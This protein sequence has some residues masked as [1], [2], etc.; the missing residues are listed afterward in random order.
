MILVSDL[1]DTLVYSTNLNNDAY[2]FALE[3]FGY[4]RVDDTARI[5][6][7]C[8]D[9][10]P[11]QILK[12][13]VEEKQQYF[14]LNWMKYRLILNNPLLK[15]LKRNGKQNCIL[16]TKANKERANA[17]IDAFALNKI[18]K[19]IIFDDKTNFKKSI[20]RIKV[21]TDENKIIFYENEESSFQN[22]KPI[23]IIDTTKT[24][25]FDVKGYLVRI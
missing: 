10:V 11:R 9:N 6:R 15:I 23:R 3:K 8:L 7:E 13:I 5:T 14:S 22:Y 20:K 19:D 16:W 24:D 17:I 21:L 1:D 25:I 2:N 18:F 4:P 12:Q